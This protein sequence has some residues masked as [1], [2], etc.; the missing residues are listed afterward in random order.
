VDLGRKTL[1]TASAMGRMF[2]TVAAGFAELEWKMNAS[3]P[4]TSGGASPVYAIWSWPRPALGRRRSRRPARSPRSGSR[5]HR[6]AGVMTGLE[7]GAR[8]WEASTILIVYVS[9]YAGELNLIQTNTS[10]PV[11]P[12][13]KSFDAAQ[14]QT[15]LAQ[16]LAAH[17]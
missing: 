5:G 4:L 1:N 11:F 14:L 12:F 7:T 10:T 3:S 8:I 9:A 2:L 16:A 13:R 17:R 15:I 6:F